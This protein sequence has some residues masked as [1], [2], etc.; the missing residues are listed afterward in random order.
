MYLASDTLP[1]P[2]QWC[3]SGPFHWWH[4][5]LGCDA[6]F[7]GDSPSHVR[8][9]CTLTTELKLINNFWTFPAKYPS[10]CNT[11]LKRKCGSVISTRPN[12]GPMMI[13]LIENI[14]MNLQPIVPD[15]KRLFGFWRWTLEESFQ[16]FWLLRLFHLK[17]FRAQNLRNYQSFSRKSTDYKKEVVVE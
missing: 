3:H 1:L 4:H 13:I 16:C 8:E 6:V 17:L 9:D 15:Y 12:F 2:D 10:K 14:K 7:W 11:N 5:W